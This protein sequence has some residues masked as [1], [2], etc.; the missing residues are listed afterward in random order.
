MLGVM[1]V[2]LGSLFGDVQQTLPVAATFLMFMTPVIY[3]QPESGLAGA[4]IRWNPLTPVIT[5]TRDWLT[6]GASEQV[7]AFVLVSIVSVTLLFI[8]WVMY[9]LALPHIIARMGS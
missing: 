7:G 3:P 5:V 2:P 6:T 4:V 8:A 9:R 1:L